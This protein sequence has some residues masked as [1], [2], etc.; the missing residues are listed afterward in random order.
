[1]EI[2]IRNMDPTLVKKIDEMAKQK[3]LSRD[4]F[5]RIYVS[6]LALQG[7]LIELEDKYATLVKALADKIEQ[8]NDIIERNSLVLASISKE[9]KSDS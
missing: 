5:L 7:D 9:S 2:K 3:H 4:R 8:S 1:M 6:Q